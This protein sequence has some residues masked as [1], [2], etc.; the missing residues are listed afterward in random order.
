MVWSEAAASTVTVTANGTLGGT[1]SIGGK[2]TVNH[3]GWLTPGMSPGVLAVGELQLNAGSTTFMEIDGLLRGTEYD[4]VDIV[5][6]DGLAYGGT[7][8]LA[9][10]QTGPFPAGS[11]FD[12]FHFTGDASGSFDSV[13]SSG[14][15]AGEWEWD[16]I[17]TYA[18]AAGWQTLLFSHATG[19]LTIVPE[20]SA[21]AL[22]ALALAALGLC[23]P[24][25]RRRC[26][27]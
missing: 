22:I 25:R 6:E 23:R 15:Y 18:L 8:S 4:G 26:Q 13:V 7:L 10:N 3:S 14:Y 11:V 19:N 27:A 16:N 1:G 17:D 5:V 12:L 9:F 20:P 21:F 24:A 2:V